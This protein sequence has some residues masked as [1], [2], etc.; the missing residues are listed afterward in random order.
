M[1]DRPRVLRDIKK[2]H[3]FLE[4]ALFLH[5]ISCISEFITLLNIEPG[6][7]FIPAFNFFE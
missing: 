2:G 4:D 7:P 5:G 3:P 1:L 6:F